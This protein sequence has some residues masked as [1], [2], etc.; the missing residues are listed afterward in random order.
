M[1]TWRLPVSLYSRHSAR[2]SSAL[3]RRRLP[4]VVG[5]FMSGLLAWRGRELTDEACIGARPQVLHRRFVV[6]RISDKPY[7]HAR[8]CATAVHICS[9]ISSPR[10][11][12]ASAEASSGSRCTGTPASCARS[13]IEAAICPLPA[14]TTFGAPSPVYLSA[15]VT[16]R[17]GIQIERLT[18]WPYV[19]RRLE[20]DRLQRG[21]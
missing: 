3:T 18:A 16:L 1:R 10:A 14:A 12:W 13:R 19:D 7:A 6:G 20:A 15:A 11:S 5:D 4:E 2:A 17:S 21:A 8:T 9:G